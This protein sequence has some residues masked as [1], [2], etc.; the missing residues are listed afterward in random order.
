LEVE[1]TANTACATTP[2]NKTGN[3]TVPL[4]ETADAAVPYQKVSS[5]GAQNP[6]TH[7]QRLL[8]AELAATAIFFALPAMLFSST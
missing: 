8:R 7:R 1:K 4:K 3:A 2:V 6:K 5:V